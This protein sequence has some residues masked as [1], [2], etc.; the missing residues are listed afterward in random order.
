MLLKKIAEVS[1]GKYHV[2]TQDTDLTGTRFENPEVLVKT[3]TKS[4]SLWDNWW[5]YGLILIFLLMDWYTRRKSG[6]S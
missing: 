4:M 5:S 2:L 6:L 1:G 3:K